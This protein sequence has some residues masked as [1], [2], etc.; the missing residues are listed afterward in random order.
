[1]V[2]RCACYGLASVLLFGLSGMAWGQKTEADRKAQVEQYD[3]KHVRYSTGMSTDASKDFLKVPDSYAGKT[4]FIMAKVVPEI[5]FAPIRNLW[6]EFFPED[7]KG[8]WS[9]WG[10][11]T[12]GPNGKFYMAAG[13][14]RC[15]DGQ[16]FIVEYDAAAKEQRVVVDVGKICGWKKGQYVDGKI[17]GCMSIMPD[18]T[19]VAATWNGSPIKQEWLDHGYVK[20]G[21]L[22]TYNVLTGNA[23]Y[24]GSPFVGD[25]WP[26]HVTDTQTGVFM[27]V[28]AEYYFMAYDVKHRKLL[29]GGMPPDGIK[30]NLRSTLLDLR[31]G[32]LYATDSSTPDNFFISY[33]QRTNH[34][35]RL[36]C[37]TPPN[38]VSGKNSNMRAYTER[39]TP[40]GIFYCMD[41]VGT[42]FKFWPDQEKTETIGVNWDKSGVYTTSVDISPKFRYVYYVPGAHGEAYKLGVPV[43]QYDTKTGQK[44]VLAFLDK[45]YQD[46]YGYVMAGT[47][48]I[49]LSPDGSLLVIEMN[50]GFGPP[51]SRFEHPSII[52]VH[53]PE[54]ERAE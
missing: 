16:V 3:K 38:P 46:N 8:L 6:P 7:N 27:A 49:E 40:D 22:L 4:D 44:K 21:H 43:I 45:F 28:G 51:A 53:I 15:K 24:H 25:S 10:E 12:R 31:T 54:S 36:A 19:L 39:R 23:E 42:M 5:D 20:G 33:D 26:Y 34:F 35:A 29:Y 18:G 30:W 17:H 1:M 11:V 37:K 41:Q 52:A 47:F 13:D 32:I 9:S 14:H 2:K 50:G 48:G